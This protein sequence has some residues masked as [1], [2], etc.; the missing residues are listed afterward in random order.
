MDKKAKILVADDDEAT[1]E[2]YAEV[3]AGS[4]FQVITAKDG[5]E[6][7]DLATR[8]MPDV[9]FTGI[10]MPRMDGFSMVEALK[11]NVQTAS[12]PIVI[13]SHMGREADR[14]K[15]NVLGAKDFIVR[16]LTPPKDVIKRVK[17]LFAGG[18]DYQ[19]DFQP[20]NLDAQ[21]LARDL[22]LNTNF[23]CLECN[24]KMVLR[25][26][27]DNPKSREFQAKFVCPACGWEAK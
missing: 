1:R 25:L 26:K 16:D 7:L 14:Q 22:G 10:V 19:I 23:Q 18:S 6:G 17:A 4:G 27:L 8:E 21:K 13:S 5:V 9:I 11:K 24:Q 20:Y 2:M 3:F 15:A 12:I